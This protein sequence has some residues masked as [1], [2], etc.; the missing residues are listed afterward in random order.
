MDRAA[1]K[2]SITSLSQGADVVFRMP[3]VHTRMSRSA[4]RLSLWP[5]VQKG[6]SACFERIHLKESCIAAGLL[7]Y[8]WCYCKSFVMFPDTL[9]HSSSQREQRQLSCGGHGCKRNACDCMR[10]ATVVLLLIGVLTAL[11]TAVA[12]AADTKVSRR[13]RRDH[14]FSRTLSDHSSGSMPHGFYSRSSE[15]SDPP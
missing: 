7:S 3:D 14:A 11:E 10:A 12:A 6:C 5:S 13:G 1:A 4:S 9:N 15:V 8:H 2:Q